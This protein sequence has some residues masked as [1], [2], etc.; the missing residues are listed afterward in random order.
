M[1]AAKAL[2]RLGGGAY[3]RMTTLILSDEAIAS[4]VDQRLTMNDA[5][6]A[7]SFPG[8][9]DWPAD[10]QLGLLSM[11]WSMGPAFRPKFPRFA[12]ACD[13]LDFATAAIESKEDETGNPGLIPRNSADRLLFSNAAV[14]LAQGLDPNVLHWPAAL[15][16]APPP[17]A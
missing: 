5:Y 15:L 12:A 17:A 11:A 4:L 14:V 9:V 8:Y 7:R 2:N 3:E 16:A 13:A 10:A 1:K 6:L